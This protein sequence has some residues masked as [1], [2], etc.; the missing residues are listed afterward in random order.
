MS[1]FSLEKQF[2]TP[3]IRWY[4][5]KEYITLNVEVY[6]AKNEI[7]KIMA[8]NISFYAISKENIYKI[9]FNLYDNI[10][11]E[12]SKYIV[13]DKSIRITLK[14]TSYINWNYLLK[15]KN[16][17]KNNIKID[18]NEWINDLDE[19]ETND[20]NQFDFQKIMES[21]K[22]MGGG[23]QQNEGEDE[24]YEECEADEDQDNNCCDENC[25][26][27]LNNDDNEED[28]EEDEE[29]DN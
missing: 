14:K 6:D 5:T 16:C 23:L 21:M 11:V 25:Q 24:E 2:F 1:E 12:E 28:E 13:N 8:D 17:Y 27:E 9:D 29:E 4:Q 20:S 7:V 22:G 26:H 15:D 19:E 10:N 18:W 3:T